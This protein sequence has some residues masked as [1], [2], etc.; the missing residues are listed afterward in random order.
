MML[1]SCG[2]STDI[3]NQRC[4][5]TLTTPP[6]R[7]VVATTFHTLEMARLHYS[8]TSSQNLPVYL[9]IIIFCVIHRMSERDVGFYEAVASNEHGEVRQRVRLDIAEYPRFI[10]RL[11]ET[12][13]M[14]RRNGRLEVRVTGIPEPEVKW[15]KDW[16]L[17]TDSARIKVNA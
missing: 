3:L 5:T 9:S 17:I 13:I 15:Y 16:Q 8:S 6:L 7:R 1:I 4:L 11:D 14:S 2:S 12:Y 10:K